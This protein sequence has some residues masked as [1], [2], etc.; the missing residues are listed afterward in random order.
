MQQTIHH[1]FTIHRPFFYPIGAGGSCLGNVGSHT[2][3]ACFGSGS[4]LFNRTRSDR[5]WI[6]FNMS[7]TA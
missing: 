2:K 6:T 3:K 5:E 1:I 7:F 4:R